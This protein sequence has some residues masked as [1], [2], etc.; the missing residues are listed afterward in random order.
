ICSLTSDQPQR[1][2]PAS[3]GRPDVTAVVVISPLGLPDARSSPTS[4]YGA[5]DPLRERRTAPGGPAL[6][7]Q[8]LGDPGARHAD[9]HWRGGGRPVG[10]SGRGRGGGGKGGPH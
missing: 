2:A 6:S 5:P 9:G 1:S 8:A 3:P 7:G 10:F 4:H